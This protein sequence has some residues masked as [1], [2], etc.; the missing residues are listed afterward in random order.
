MDACNRF[1]ESVMHVACR[2]SCAPMVSPCLTLRCCEREAQRTCFPYAAAASP[3]IFP[4]SPSSAVSWFLCLHFSLIFC[5]CLFHFQVNF[6]I[7]E[8]GMKVNTSDDFGRTPLH[9]ACWTA[10][11]N[12]E[13]VSKVNPKSQ[14]KLL[15]G[16][17]S[18]TGGGVSIFVVV[19]NFIF[20][21]LIQR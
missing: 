17:K 14:K 9:D 10:E 15:V 16:H 21:F 12:F 11:P 4:F 6:F 19:I 20:I 3:F 13:V 7:D 8:C 1:G 2:R 5:L 18:D